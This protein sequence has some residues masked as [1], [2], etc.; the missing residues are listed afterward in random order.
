MHPDFDDEWEEF[1]DD[2]YDGADEM[3]IRAHRSL[4]EKCFAKPD[5]DKKEEDKDG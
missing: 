5:A 3:L 4:L 1:P 2:W